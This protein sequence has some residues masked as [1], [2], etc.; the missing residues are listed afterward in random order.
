[1]K[2]LI[3]TI[4]ALAAT[5]AAVSAQNTM[6]AVPEG[7][8]IVDSL[9]YIPVS[10]VDTTVRGNIFNILPEG[11][12][13]RQDG[14]VRDA[15]NAKTE[16]NAAKMQHGFRIRIYFDNRQDARGRSSAILSSFQTRYPGIPAY[17]NFDAPFFKVTVGNFRTKAD[18]LAFLETIKGEYPSAFL[19][20]EEFKYPSL[21]SASDF[22]VDTV[23]VLRKKQK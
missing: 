4:L 3:C 2:K 16:K 20:R 5:A 22:V 9:I 23:K 21:D 15:V 18:A 6:Q 13:I 14:S 17:R 1:M 10:S 7:Y 11:V 8:E 12:T 19:V